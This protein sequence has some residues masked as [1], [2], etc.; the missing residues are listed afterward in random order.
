MITTSHFII[1][2]FCLSLLRLAESCPDQW[3]FGRKSPA[4]GPGIEAP[5]RQQGGQVDN[6]DRLHWRTRCGA[7]K[8]A[9]KIEI[10]WQGCFE[11]LARWRREAKEAEGELK[12]KVAERE[13]MIAV[14]IKENRD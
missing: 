7:G 3:F 11:G 12:L 4:S 14:A 5:E 13:E 9:N 2:P 1:P 6:D 10:F 8:G